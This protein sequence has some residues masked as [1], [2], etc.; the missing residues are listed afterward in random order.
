VFKGWVTGRFHAMG[1]PEFKL[2]SPTMEESCF[3]YQ[4]TKVPSHRSGHRIVATQRSCD[5]FE[6]ANLVKP[7]DHM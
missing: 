4:K 3:M 7:G 2:Y 5:P 6:I 1:Q